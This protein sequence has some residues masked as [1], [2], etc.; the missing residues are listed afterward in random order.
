MGEDPQGVPYN[1][2]PLLAQVAIGKRDKLLVF[3]DGRAAVSH[4]GGPYG[5]RFLT[6]LTVDYASK[7][8][9]AIRDYI[10]ILDLAKGIWSRSTTSVSIT[11]V[12]ERGI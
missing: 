10:H 7:D 9:T 4:S 8:G 12:S 11:P 1:L 5:L 3:G 2:L 6:K